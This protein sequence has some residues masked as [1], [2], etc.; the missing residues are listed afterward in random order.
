M[1]LKDDIKKQFGVDVVERQVSIHEIYNSYLEERLISM[2][3]ASTYC[4]LLPIKR[5]VYKDKTID[6][7]P[8][9]DKFNQGLNKMLT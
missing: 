3:G 8:D 7:S 9:G 5:V 1:D 6:L 2:F 4:P